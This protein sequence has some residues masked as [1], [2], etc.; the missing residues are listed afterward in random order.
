ML[1][2]TVRELTLDA[3]REFRF[4]PGQWV[5]LRLPQPNGEEIARAYSIASA[6][7]DDGRFDLAVTRVD[8]GP[9]SEFLH[10][11]EPG[12]TLRMTHAQGFFTLEPAAR[13]ILLVAT[14]T[15]ISPLRSMLI[16]G[17][18]DPEVTA[19]PCVLLFGC[20][21][22]ADVLYAADFEAL[23]TAWPGFRFEPT[24]SRAGAGWTGRTGYVQTHVPEL[25]RALGG[26]CD[27]YA[28]G[29]SKMIREVRA[30]LKDQLGFTRE[31][32]HTERYD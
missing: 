10:A 21:T 18:R 31:R 2:P 5:S 4:V 12:A 32:I 11:I 6:P 15:G 9:G 14:G 23:P 20:R 13:P 1:S 30:V 16:A 27:V 19:Q 25:V 8:G 7:R 26:D 22:A 29:L 24:L 28:C 17:A 3:G